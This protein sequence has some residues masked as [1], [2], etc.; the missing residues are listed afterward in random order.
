MEYGSPRGCPR[1][2]SPSGWYHSCT[3]SMSQDVARCRPAAVL[4]GS[5]GCRWDQTPTHALVLHPGV[6]I[7]PLPYGG[8]SSR[9]CPTIVFESRSVS[10]DCPSVAECLCHPYDQLSTVQ[11]CTPAVRLSG[12]SVTPTIRAA[13]LSSYLRSRSVGLSRSTQTCHMVLFCFVSRLPWSDLSS[14]PSFPAVPSVPSIP[15]TLLLLPRWTDQTRTADY[16]QSW[17][18]RGSAR[19]KCREGVCPKCPVSC[20]LKLAQPS[21]RQVQRSANRQEARC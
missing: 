12:Q 21:A 15:V 14:V 7:C 11:D 19:A 9:G 3:A 16:R 18:D 1:G 10:A 5:G 6:S 8:Q 17:R 20:C 13:V 2:A 4:A